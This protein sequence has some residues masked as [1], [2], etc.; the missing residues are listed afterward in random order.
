MRKILEK[1]DEK[2]TKLAKIA[3]IY[4]FSAFCI[5]GN[6]LA[7]FGHLWYFILNFCC[8][9]AKKWGRWGRRDCRAVKI[10]RGGGF[11]F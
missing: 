3:H 10:L 7:V 4:N 11:K 8:K 1:N 9:C 6:F 5:F 2:S